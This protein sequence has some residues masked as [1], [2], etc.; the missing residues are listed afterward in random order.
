VASRHV[1]ERTAHQA[2]VAEGFEI[3][4]DEKAAEQA[5]ETLAIMRIGVALA[6]LYLL[7][8]LASPEAGPDHEDR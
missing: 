8:E 3:A 1:E 4:G 5:M 2:A 6:H 7:V